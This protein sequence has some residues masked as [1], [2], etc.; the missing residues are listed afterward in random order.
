M[1]KMS[2]GDAVTQS[3]ISHGV[4]TVFGLPGAQVYGLFDAFHRAGH[5]LTVIGARHEQATAYMAYG[6]AR[7]SGKVGVCAVVPGP[8]VL[9]AGAGLCTAAGANLP[10]LCL[11]GQ[12]PSHFLGQGRGHLHELPDQR[13][14]LRSFIKW[15]ERIDHPA[16][17]SHI[18]AEAFKQM[19]SGR[20][21]PAAVEIPWDVFGQVGE[22]S[23]VKPLPNTLPMAPD[24]DRVNAAAQLVASAKRPMIVVGSGAIG[25]RSQVLALAERLRAPVLA[26]RGGRGIVPDDNELSVNGVAAYELWH[27]TDL[28]IAIGTRLELTHMRWQRRP[29]Q[30]KLLR[31]DIDPRELVRLS[32]DVGLVADARPATAMLVEQLA[33]MAINAQLSVDTIRAAKASALTKIQSVEPYYSYLCAIREVLPRDGILVKDLCQAGYTSYYGFPVYEPRTYITSGYQGTLGY[34]FMAALGAKVARPDTPVVAIAGDGGFM[35]GVQELATAVQYGINVVTIVFDNNAYGNVRRDQHNHYQGRVIASDLHNPDF[36]AL[37]ESFG[38]AAYRAES[39]AA[40]KQTLQRALAQRRPA[41][42][43]VPVDSDT[44]GNP[45]PL[46]HPA[47]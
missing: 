29:A 38:A 16:Q 2:C 1:A 35:F 25:A 46:L 26:F 17:A 11:T 45:W 18:I 28:V 30:Q 27:D 37:L 40:L 32:A 23:E 15:A 22:V 24:A 47:P 5:R 10:V 44:E 36:I 13:A 39:A 4:D 6:Y 19:Q 12:V 9:N 33:L 34:G 42:I 43:H 3:L 8:G 21:G 31:I 7:A 14:T 20:N 41:V